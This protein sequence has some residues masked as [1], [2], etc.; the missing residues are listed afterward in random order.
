MRSDIVI[1]GMCRGLHAGADS[2][3]AATHPQAIIDLID[4][5]I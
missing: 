5:G 2:T 3:T 1:G 4:I